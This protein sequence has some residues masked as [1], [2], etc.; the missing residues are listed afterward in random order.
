MEVGA[1]DTCQ[2]G[3]EGP[4]GEMRDPSFQEGTDDLWEKGRE[5]EEAKGRYPGGDLRGKGRGR[6]MLK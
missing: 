5:R 4:R 2:G 1:W 3:W 6:E